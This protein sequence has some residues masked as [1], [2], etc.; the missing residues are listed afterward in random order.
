MIPDGDRYAPPVILRRLVSQGRLGKKTGQGF[1][2]YP[3][4]DADFDQKSTGMSALF[5][6]P[7]TF[8]ATA[9]RNTRRRMH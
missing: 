5:A 7:R 1:F 8:L 2:P 4:P 9:D 6:P 3:R